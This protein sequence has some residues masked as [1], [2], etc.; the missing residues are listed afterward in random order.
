MRPF[1][2][3]ASHSAHDFG[4]LASGDLAEMRAR[5]RRSDGAAFFGLTSGA[6]S[7]EG[8]DV[9]N[10]RLKNEGLVVGA[11]RLG[12]TNSPRDALVDSTVSGVAAG[13]ESTPSSP[14]RS[15]G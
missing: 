5:L 1:A 3:N 11:T 7:S 8:L 6:G 4:H 9:E 15:S 13:V 2:Y 14:A 10:M 12:G